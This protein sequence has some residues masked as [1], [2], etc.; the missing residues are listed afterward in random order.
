M[1][2]PTFSIKDWSVFESIHRTNNSVEGWHNKLNT[3]AYHHSNLNMYL[4]INILYNKSVDNALLLRFMRDGEIQPNKRKAIY[5]K[6]DK[7][8]SSVWNK[9]K[10]G[11]II[12]KQVLIVASKCTVSF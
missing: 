9:L 12:A 4:L 11:D 2:N 3:R 1:N 6:C 5:I 10:K 8:I 7:R